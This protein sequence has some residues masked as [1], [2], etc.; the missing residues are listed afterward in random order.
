MKHRLTTIPVD[1]KRMIMSLLAGRDITSLM[2]TCSHLLDVGLY[3]SVHGYN[4]FWVGFL[5]MISSLLLIGLLDL[6]VSPSSSPPQGPLEHS[7]SHI[8][9]PMQRP[10]GIRLFHQ[11]AIVV[12]TTASLAYFSMAFDLSASSVSFQQPGNAR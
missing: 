7:D 10:R 3:L 4:W 5:F 2:Q 9:S 11:I 1:L 12:L 6:I 8:S